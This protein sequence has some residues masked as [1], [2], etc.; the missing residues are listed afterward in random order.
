[1]RKPAAEWISAGLGLIITIATFV[2]VAS[3][4]GHVSDEAP[5]INLI[6]EG[7]ERQ[8]SGFLVR[9]R[10]E[11]VSGA[12]AAAFQFEGTLRREGTVIE[13]STAT[14]DYVPRGSTK[15]GGLWFTADPSSG[16][17]QVRSMGYQEP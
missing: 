15:T 4:L 2:L 11:N 5:E 17:L 1:M 16:E 7:I 9:V 14:L 10:A 6:V 13:R 3:D 8:P 12:T